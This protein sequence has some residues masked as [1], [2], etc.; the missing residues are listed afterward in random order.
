MIQESLRELYMDA[1]VP[2]TTLVTSKETKKPLLQADTDAVASIRPRE[3]GGIL[4]D[5][6]D[7]DDEDIAEAA[8][9][10]M[11]MAEGVS[12]EEYDH[13]DDESVG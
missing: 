5:L 8:Y 9:E 11:A 2:I 3:A 7:S 6:T 1:N 13:G 12:D 10:A 4:V